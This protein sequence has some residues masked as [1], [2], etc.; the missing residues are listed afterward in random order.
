[1]TQLA[2][3]QSPRD[4]KIEEQVKEM[5]ARVIE[6]ESNKTALITVN[7]VE[8]FEKGRRA[9]IYITVMPET[10]EESALNFLKRKRADMRDEIKK[11]L[12]IRTIPFLDV[13]IDLGE[14]ASRRI[15]ELLKQ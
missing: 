11:F 1:M 3:K 7:R 13:E 14:K 5:A 12:K 8:L 4:Q 2:A 15:D 6:R 10:G 9:T